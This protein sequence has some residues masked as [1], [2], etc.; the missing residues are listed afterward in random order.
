MNI[1]IKL[2]CVCLF[3]CLFLSSQSSDSFQGFAVPTP[4][5]P[6][7]PPLNGLNSNGSGERAFPVRSLKGSGHGPVV[8]DCSLVQLRWS[9]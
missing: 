4:K 2:T 7:L 5:V 3:V 8:I 6:L 9:W 1:N